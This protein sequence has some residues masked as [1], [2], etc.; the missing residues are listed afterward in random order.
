[1]L[2]SFGVLPARTH[3]YT[4]SALICSPCISLMDITRP[5]LPTSEPPF[6]N[7]P[8]PTHVSVITEQIKLVKMSK[9][10]TRK[11][12]AKETKRER[13]IVRVS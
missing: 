3:S 4:V 13:V 12:G 2:W 8:W 11:E 6:Y 7:V 9:R 10:D 5:H 1:M